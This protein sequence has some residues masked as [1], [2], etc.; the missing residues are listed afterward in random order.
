MI[1]RFGNPPKAGQ[2]YI[3]RPGAYAILPRRG[4]ILL[5]WQGDPHNEVQL[6]GGGIDAGESALTA[7][8]REV[9]EETGWH[10]A[11]PR[12]LGTFKRFTL[13]PEYDLCAEKVCHIFVATPTI[14]ISAPIEPDHIAIWMHPDTALRTLFNDG[15]ASFLAGLL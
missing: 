4:Q 13:M 1:R 3:Q 14:K 7:L 2:R 11:K 10:I 12:R 15:D 5:T 6:Q 8:H 9:F